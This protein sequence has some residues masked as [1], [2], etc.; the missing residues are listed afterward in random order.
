MQEDETCGKQKECSR[1]NENNVASCSQE[2][3]GCDESIDT[4][5]E[6]PAKNN[7]SQKRETTCICIFCFQFAAPIQLMTSF[8]FSCS[9]MDRLPFTYIDMPTKDPYIGAPWQPPD[10]V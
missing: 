10:F 3:Q 6:E 2:K 9:K 8:K 4:T 1:N 5:E 7:C